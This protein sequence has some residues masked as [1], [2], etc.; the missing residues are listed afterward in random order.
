MTFAARMNA[1][2]YPVADQNAS[3]SARTPTIADVAGRCCRSVI[4]C[5][6]MSRAGPGARSR[7]SRMRS[8]VTVL[9]SRPN[10]AT[11]TSSPGKIDMM[12]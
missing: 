2:M 12:A 3:A 5:T 7:T 4:P 11:S 6:M 9:S 1:P 10:P 8:S